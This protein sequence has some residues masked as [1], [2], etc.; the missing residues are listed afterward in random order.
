MNPRLGTKGPCHDSCC[1]IQQATVGSR[2]AVSKSVQ[3][4]AQACT[5]NQTP[6]LCLHAET[7]VRSQRRLTGMS[8]SLEGAIP[9]NWHVLLSLVS[10]KPVPHRVKP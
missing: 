4:M 8:N 9:F 3:E 6:A 5:I 1:R 2:E 7:D 10:L